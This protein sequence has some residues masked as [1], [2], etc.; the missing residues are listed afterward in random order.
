M[1]ELLIAQF[2]TYSQ[3]TNVDSTWLIVK[4]LFLLDWPRS[5]LVRSQN[6]RTGLNF[7]SSVQSGLE[8]SRT[9]L[10]CTK[11]TVQSDANNFFV[12]L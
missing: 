8:K 4:G 12:P 10:D 6:F 1:S 7:Y 9:G 5:G 2:F 11:K 3:I